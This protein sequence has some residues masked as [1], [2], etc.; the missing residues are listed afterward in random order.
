MIGYNRVFRYYKCMKL[1]QSNDQ[2]V[3]KQGGAGQLI[4]GLIFII[5]GIGVAVVFF[6]GLL[7]ADSNGRHAPILIGLIGLL[8]AGI[9]LVLL[10]SAQNRTI[11]IQ[12][13]GETTGHE[14]NWPQSS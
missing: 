4:A 8:F 2:M 6:G 10:R 12:K 14:N 9:G 13:G 11:T 1:I 3:I 5:I 7:P